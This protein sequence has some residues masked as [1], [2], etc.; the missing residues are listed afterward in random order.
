MTEVD[1]VA[2][3]WVGTK[4]QGAAFESMILLVF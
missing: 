1:S 3:I 4:V 2:D